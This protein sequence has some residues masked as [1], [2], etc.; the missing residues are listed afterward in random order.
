MF[1]ALNDH[2]ECLKLILTQKININWQDNVRNTS[3]FYNNKKVR[4]PSL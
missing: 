4:K 1:A 2:T 3:V